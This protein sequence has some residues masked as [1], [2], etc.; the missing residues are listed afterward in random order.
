MLLAAFLAALVLFELFLRTEADVL[1][2]VPRVVD[3]DTLEIGERNVRLAGL[4]A[5]ERAQDCTDAAGEP[6]A[7]GRSATDYLRFLID[8]RAVTCRGQGTDRWQRLI[9]R[10][11]VNGVDL[12][13]AMIRRG[14]A[15]AFMGDLEA[16]EVEAREAGVGM[17]A[18][19]FVRPADWRRERRSASIV[20]SFAAVGDAA[21]TIALWLRGEPVLRAPADE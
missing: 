1:A 17:W 2:G 6:F 11:R 12:S 7:C 14:W 21:R 3:G 5:P 8:G 16:F 13:E 4:D 15:V 19:E 9:A 10:C 20:P 18:G